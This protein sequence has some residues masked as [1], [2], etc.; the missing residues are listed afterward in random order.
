MKLRD[1]V[2]KKEAF[3]SRNG[4]G[5]GKYGTVTTY[6][7]GFEEIIEKTQHRHT[8]ISTDRKFRFRGYGFI[9]VQGGNP[10]CNRISILENSLGKRGF[11]FGD[12]KEV[13]TKELPKREHYNGVVL[14]YDEYVERVQ[15]H[16][17]YR[18]VELLK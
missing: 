12:V 9:Y 17:L 16:F 8:G 11:A 15:K 5:M 14:T 10:N 13:L 2:I 3:N 1:K 4:W 18:Q 6:A 7:S